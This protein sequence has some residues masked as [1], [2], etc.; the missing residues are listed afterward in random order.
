LQ[1]AGESEWFAGN[2][3]GCFVGQPFALAEDGHAWTAMNALIAAQIIRMPTQIPASVA[4]QSSPSLREVIMPMPHS[5][6][7]MVATLATSDTTR[8][9]PSNAAEYSAMRVS[10]LAMWLNSCAVTPSSSSSSRSLSNPV[11]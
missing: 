5:A 8:A 7:P 6:M 11:L 1:G 4:V 10:P 9:H 2:A 3:R